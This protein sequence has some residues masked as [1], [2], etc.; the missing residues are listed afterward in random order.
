MELN[1]KSLIFSIVFL[2]AFTNSAY[3]KWATK[4]KTNKNYP[5]VGE[6]RKSD[7]NRLQHRIKSKD[8]TFVGFGPAWFKHGRTEAAALNIAAAKYWDVAPQAAIHLRGDVVT[9]FDAIQDTDLAEY[10]ISAALGM[11]YFFNATNFTPF[12]GADLGFGT[13]DGETPTFAIGLQ[14]GLFFFRTSTMQMSLQPTYNVLLDKTKHAT[15]GIKVGV[16]F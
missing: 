9:N 6:V 13:Y 14:A 5:K 12:V 10:M 7:Q 1:M 16:H 11:D 15:Y 2:F 8:F 4:K 3:A